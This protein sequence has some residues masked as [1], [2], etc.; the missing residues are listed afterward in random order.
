MHATKFIPLFLLLTLM[1]ILPATASAQVLKTVPPSLHS[2]QTFRWTLTPNQVQELSRNVSSGTVFSFPVPSGPSQAMIAAAQQRHGL[3]MAPPQ[4]ATTSGRGTLLSPTPV[5]LLPASPAPAMGSLQT[6]AAM[7]SGIS[8]GM[9]QPTRTTTPSNAG[10]PTSSSMTG[11][12]GVIPRSL[13]CTKPVVADVDGFNGSTTWTYVE[14][15][16]HYVI[17]G[18][19]FGSQPGEVYLVGVKHAPISRLSQVST[20]QYLG[21]QHH[22]GWIQLIPAPPNPNPQHKQIWTDTQIQ[23]I[24]DPNASGFYDDF[25][26]D[27]TVIVLPAGGKP[28]IQSSPGFG[29]WAARVE[30]P[31]PLPSI[32]LPAAGPVNP[33]QPS[34][35]MVAN[36]Q[37]VVANTQTWFTPAHVLDVKGAPVQ[38]N[39]LSPSAASVVLPGHTFAVV[40]EDNGAQFVGTH[41]TLYLAPSLLRLTQGFQVSRLILFSASLPP[42]S[43]N[44]S[45][46]S[47]NGNWSTTWPDKYDTDLIL[48][49]WQEQ[50]CGQGG[51]SI[52]ALDVYVSGPRGIPAQY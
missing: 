33:K 5:T 41:D 13:P 8:P 2:S 25:P 42:T 45:D 15:G 39:L 20:P 9:T 37:F 23:V 32:P 12:L 22:P 1:S 11:K 10:S 18:C 44:V 50:I 26:G 30:Q 35:P 21:V 38:P 36:P 48:V 34:P 4:A 14:P 7:S 6:Q 28:Q 3:R 31:Q 19:G 29:F 24:V 43:C 46:V 27:A 40:R 51:F 47:P 49:S 17:D 16:K 52:Y